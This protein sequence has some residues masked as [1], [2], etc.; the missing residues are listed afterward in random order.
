MSNVH[1]TYTLLCRRLSAVVIP[2][3]TRLQHTAAPMECLSLARDAAMAMIAFSTTNLGDAFIRTPIQRIMC[4]SNDSSLMFNFQLGKTVR[5]GTDQLLTAPY[6]KDDLT[7]CPI[8]LV[9]QYVRVVKRQFGHEK[10]T[11]FSTISA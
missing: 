2:P 6:D 10:Y 5:D 4:P 3:W 8:L 1:Q 9:E 7:I 11:G